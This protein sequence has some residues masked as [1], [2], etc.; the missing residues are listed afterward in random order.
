MKFPLLLFSNGLILLQPVAGGPF[1][2]IADKL[3]KALDK[4]V[5]VIVK[6]HRWNRTITVD[7]FAR[8]D[9]ESWCTVK[10]K[11]AYNVVVS[12]RQRG[13][14]QTKAQKRAATDGQNY[15]EVEFYIKL[16][17]R[18]PG[19]GS[20]YAY[21]DFI[22]HYEVQGSVNAQAEWD[23]AKPVAIFDSN[24]DPTEAARKVWADAPVACES[25][26]WVSSEADWCKYTV[27]RWFRMDAVH[28]SGEDVYPYWPRV[29]VTNC[30][31]VGCTR[32]RLRKASHYLDLA[33]RKKGGKESKTTC[34]I[35]KLKWDLNAWRS[36]QVGAELSGKTRIGY[37]LVCSSLAAPAAWPQEK[38]TAADGRKGTYADFIERYGSPDGAGDREWS[39]ATPMRDET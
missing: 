7:E 32:A 12:K 38:R 39:A 13:R 1:T 5:D 23:A 18:D 37:G 10:P 9:Q 33:V 21:Q 22:Q 25:C 2:W 15:T 26:G 27:E 19:D 6:G 24:G 11:K 17:L 36:V 14:S 30:T 8:R 35:E 29:E 3:D 4:A 28:T 34:T 16:D 20:A 31:E